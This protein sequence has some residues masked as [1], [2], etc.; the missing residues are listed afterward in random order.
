MRLGRRAVAL[1]N[2]IATGESCGAH[3]ELGIGITILGYLQYCREPTGQALE[4]FSRGLH[5]ARD[6]GN[7]QHESWALTMMVPLWLAPGDLTEARRSVQAAGQKLATSDPLSVPIYHGVK[8]QMLWRSGEHAAAL[9]AADDALVAFRKAPPAGYIY[10]PGLTGLCEVAVGEMTR[11]GGDRARG[12]RLAAATLGVYRGFALLFPFARARQDLLRGRVAEASGEQ[13]AA[14]PLR[15]RPGPGPPR[16]AAL[17]A[18]ARAVGR[19][20]VAGRCGGGG[21]RAGVVGGFGGECFGV[22]VVGCTRRTPNR[23]PPAT[24][25]AKRGKT[26]LTAGP[27]RIH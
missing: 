23:C 14:L 1:R 3:Y 21:G 4:T 10:L 13:A 8:A 19:V 22:A 26:A 17:G 15:R 5:S 18:G 12:K 7:L 16:W 24:G 9:T 27:S 11:P 20:A 2:G 6:R 25:A